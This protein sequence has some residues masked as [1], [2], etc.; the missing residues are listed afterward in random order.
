LHERKRRHDAEVDSRDRMSE[1][2]HVNRQA[3]AGELASSIAHELNQ[4]LGSI[5][6]NA[7]T[8]EVILSSQIPD[9]NEVREILADIRRDDLR[10]S[11]VISRL[12]GF[13]KWATFEA[14]DVDLN[15]LLRDVFDFVSQQASDHNVALYLKPS[16]DAI[17]VKGDPIQLQQVLINLVVNSMDAMAAIPYGRTVLGR[18]EMDD[19]KSAVVTISDSGPGIPAEALARV[20]D[21]F[22]TTKAQGMGIGLSIS[23]TIVAAHHGRIWAESPGEGGAA[24]H[25][26]L[27]ISP[28]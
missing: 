12:R 4:P 11:D 5:L 16:P 15:A 28:A 22:F 2:A 23:R 17:W 20:F 1:L 7:E 9:L 3:T 21:P 13:V 24:F 19:K 8:A 25:V 10:A 6:T 14:R 27:P 26:S 18:A